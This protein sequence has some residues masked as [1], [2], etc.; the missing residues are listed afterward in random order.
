MMLRSPVN[1]NHRTRGQRNRGETANQNRRFPI[2]FVPKTKYDNSFRDA[3]GILF[4]ST[5][6]RPLPTAE[7]VEAKK[8]RKEEIRAKHI[9]KSTLQHRVIAFYEYGCNL[10]DVWSFGP[11]CSKKIIQFLQA[12]HTHLQKYNAAKSFFYTALT[13]HREA[14]AGNAPAHLD[15]FRERRGEN[16]R[17]V[18]RENPR[19]VELC[20]EWF[21]E[22]KSTA[23]KVQRSLR[24]HGFIVSRSTI[25]RIAKDLCFRWT[26]PWYTDVLTPAQKLKRKLFC[27]KLLRLGAHALL[28]VVANWLFTDEKWWD[29]VGPSM[30]RYV[31][32]GSKKEAKMKNQ[33]F[34]L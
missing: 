3:N 10:D 15:P 27:L 17:K 33:V 19:I 4:L 11:G 22:P 9:H 14:A 12:H 25:Y 20:D 7:Q 5:R 6:K 26:K 13:K 29:I 31:K 16:K 1:Q 23:P 24:Q 21:S 32:A 28:D 18:K 8:K 2:R 30:S 34:L